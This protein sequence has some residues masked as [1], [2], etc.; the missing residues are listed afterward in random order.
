MSV[1]G[2]GRGVIVAAADLLPMASITGVRTLE[3][4]FLS[5][6]AEVLIHHMVKTLDNP[7]GKV[8]LILPD[9]TANF[10]GNRAVGTEANLKTCKDMFDFAG[11]NMK[12]CMRPGRR[13]VGCCCKPYLLFRLFP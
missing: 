7:S 6:Q 8:N 4:D 1:V 13:S 12:R 11:N 9:M 10:T 2:A 5:P 3:L